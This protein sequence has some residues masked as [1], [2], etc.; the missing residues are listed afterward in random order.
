MIGVIYL[1]KILSKTFFCSFFYF[2][3]FN[4]YFSTYYQYL[5]IFNHNKYHIST[6]ESHDPIK[7]WIA[8]STQSVADSCYIQFL[9][10]FPSFTNT[11]G[12]PKGTFLWNALLCAPRVLIVLRCTVFSQW[13]IS[14][15]KFP[16]GQGIKHS[17]YFPEQ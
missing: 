1:M 4:N 5:M 8:F 17:C 6:S 13:V 9:F 3:R 12:L 14:W 11:D 7:Y 15:K 10:G 2:E 16:Y